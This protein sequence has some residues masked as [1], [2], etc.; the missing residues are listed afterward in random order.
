MLLHAMQR[1]DDD[2]ARSDDVARDDDVARG[3]D[4]ARTPLDWLRVRSLLA[5]R[6][7]ARALSVARSRPDEPLLLH[8]CCLNTKYY[9]CCCVYDVEFTFSFYCYVFVL[10]IGDC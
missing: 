7:H 8:V 9:C 10:L 3:D 4:V 2:V 1:G 6:R 5:A